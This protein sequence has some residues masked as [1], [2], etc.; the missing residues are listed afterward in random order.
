M[1]LGEIVVATNSVSFQRRIGRGLRS[2]TGRF[3]LSAN[4]AFATSGI[5]KYFRGKTTFVDVTLPSGF[6]AQ[7]FPSTT[8]KNGV[9]RI[10][11]QTSVTSAAQSG[12]SAAFWN[13]TPGELASCSFWATGF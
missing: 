1:A 12:L 8:R 6:V 10:F 2:V 3:N 4:S 5:E 13:N 7:W 9:L 11:G